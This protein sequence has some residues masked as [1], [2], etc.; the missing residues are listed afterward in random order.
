MVTASLTT[1]EILMVSHSSKIHASTATSPHKHFE[2]LRGIH[3]A[4]KISVSVSV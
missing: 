3:T 1:K 2:N 4:T